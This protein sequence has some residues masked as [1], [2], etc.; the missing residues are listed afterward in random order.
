ME[1][2]IRVLV[3]FDEDRLPKWKQQKIRE[4]LEKQLA[5]VIDKHH[6]LVFDDVVEEYHTEVNGL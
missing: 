4:I 5:E 3:R 1:F 6:L 2:E